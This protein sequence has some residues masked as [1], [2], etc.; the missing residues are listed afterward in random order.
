MLKTTGTVTITI[1]GT[2]SLVAG[3]VTSDGATV[4]IV[5]PQLY[6]V[7]VVSGIHGWITYPD[8]RHDQQH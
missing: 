4:N 5:A 3:D 7:V 8:L 6:Q 2:T 1:S